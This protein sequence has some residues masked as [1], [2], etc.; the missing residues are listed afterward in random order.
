MR[1]ASMIS[2]V[3]A[4][5]CGEPGRVIV[6]GVLD[7]PGASMFEKMRYLAEHQDGLRQRM[8]REPRGY[9]A[10][11]CNLILP[12]TCPEADAG[13]VIMEQTEY[14]P[15]SGSNTICVVTVLIET[16]MVQIVEP[17]TE[18]TLETPAGLI[19][20]RADV[21]AGKVRNDTFE[22][23][24][25]FATHLDVELDVPEFGRVTV[26]VAW[27]GMFYVIADADRL[28]IVIE[29][30]SAG[31]IARAGEMLRAAAAEQLP[32]CHPENPAVCNVSIS[33]L[34][35]PATHA[36][37]SRKNAVV[38][39]TG[40]L[41]WQRPET[42]GGVLDRS[43]CGTGTCAK[44]AVMHA[45]GELALDEDFVHEGIL[46][47]LFTGRLVRETR[48]GDYTAVVPTL[49]GRAWIT[50]FSQY[51]VDAEDP[52]PDGFKVADIWGRA[53]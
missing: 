24:P 37:A 46:G 6:G 40:E 39:S 29:P 20:V 30:D 35:A 31:A 53:T 45:K 47:T 51:V 52:Y 36:D 4:H 15:M 3:D 49:T 27:G 2:A 32:V 7:V 18:L 10:S 21:A 1:I 19:Q 48:V 34:S 8:L 13:F 14:P 16:G 43:P 25:A 12:P 5:A 38:V 33:Q 44:M 17:V 41:D 23:V 26:D 28:G 50:G 22:N 42:W 9:P 11:C